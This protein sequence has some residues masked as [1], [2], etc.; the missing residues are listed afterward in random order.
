VVERRRLLVALLLDGAA[1][2]EVDGLRRALGSTEIERIAPHLTLVAPRNVASGVEEALAVH[3]HRVAQRFG[4]LRLEL[5][6]LGLFVNRRPVVH[7]VASGGPELERLAAEL[8]DGPLAP[9]PQRPARR[10]VA[11]VTL[12]SSLDATKA[13]QAVELLAAYRFQWRAARIHLL[14]QQVELATHPWHPVEEIALG[15]PAV[16]GRG[17]RELTFRL[18][19]YERGHPLEGHQRVRVDRDAGEVA[20]ALVRRLGDALVVETLEVV[21]LEQLT[22]IGSQLLGHLELVAGELGCT[23]LVI[24]DARSPG[25][26]E[27]HGFRLRSLECYERP[28]GP[29]GQ[30][31]ER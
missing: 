4:P 28:V 30:A 9:P 10:F 22:G 31:P 15:R 14:E 21:T 3:L 17:G 29:L 23:R 1:A 11:H 24:G 19:A 25:F 27:R 12:S 26:L 16:R 7:L 6:P 8:A 5:G 2:T 20:Y 18:S 13:A